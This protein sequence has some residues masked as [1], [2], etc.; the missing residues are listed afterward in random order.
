[1]NA[2]FVEVT[3]VQKKINRRV[4]I[5]FK[6][7]Q[8]YSEENFQGAPSIRKAYIT[9]ANNGILLNSLRIKTI[10]SPLVKKQF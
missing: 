3:L 1:M 4:S 2:D 10:S 6:P 9:E 5:D 8:Q 7:I